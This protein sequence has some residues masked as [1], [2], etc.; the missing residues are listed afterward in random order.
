[1]LKTIYSII[2]LCLLITVN[3]NVFAEIP[4]KHLKKVKKGYLKFKKNGVYIHAYVPQTYN[5]KNKYTLIIALHR[6][7]GSGEEFLP[8]LQLGFSNNKNI[9]IACPDSANQWDWDGT[10]HNNY[11]AIEKVYKY[12]NKRYNID[13]DKNFLLGNADGGRF[14]TFMLAT[15]TGPQRA[16]KKKILTMFSGLI[17]I[18]TESQYEFSNKLWAFETKFS[19]PPILYLHSRYDTTSVYLRARRT[20]EILRKSGITVHYIEDTFE[21]DGYPM[22]LNEKIFKWCIENKKNKDEIEKVS[23]KALLPVFNDFKILPVVKSIAK[24]RKSNRRNFKRNKDNIV[25]DKPEYRSISEYRISDYDKIIFNV[26]FEMTEDSENKYSKKAHSILYQNIK[27][28]FQTFDKNK[29]M[30]FTD[31]FRIVGLDE[32]SKSIRKY[33]RKNYGKIFKKSD[34]LIDQK[35]SLRKGEI[36]KIQFKVPFDRDVHFKAVQIFKSGKLAAFKIFPKN[37]DY[38][39]FPLFAHLVKNKGKADEIPATLPIWLE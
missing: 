25:T 39:D 18:A 6:K 32:G 28:I 7:D 33:K 27:V 29:H 10:D 34:K 2:S 20:K 14:L 24:L 23:K 36:K 22:H 5:H 8:Q 4:E 9:I 30:T 17:I 12:F 3:I 37:T 26:P 11:R 35:A 15:G 19:T 31:E 38:K 13:A 21:W 16:K 1:M